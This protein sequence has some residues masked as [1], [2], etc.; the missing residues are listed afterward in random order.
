MCG[1]VGGGG[2]YVVGAAL[3]IS[4][5]QRSDLWDRTRGELTRFNASVLIAA[6]EAHRI[7]LGC[8]LGLSN[9]SSR[10][11]EGSCGIRQL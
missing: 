7:C 6:P 2:G 9:G 8:G 3:E 10:Y 5:R 4:H 11:K 1:S